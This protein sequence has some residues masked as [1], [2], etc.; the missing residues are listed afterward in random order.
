MYSLETNRYD[1]WAGS[2]I[3][4][5]KIEGERM[6]FTFNLGGMVR[7]RRAWTPTYLPLWSPIYNDNGQERE[8]QVERVPTVRMGREERAKG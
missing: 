8:K 1:L 5:D 7:P 3:S 4:S 2:Q 6:I